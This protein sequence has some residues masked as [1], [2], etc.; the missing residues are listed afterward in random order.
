MH[1]WEQIHS[2][3]I[4]LDWL[5]EAFWVLTLCVLVRSLVY[6]VGGQTATP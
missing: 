2:V 3:Q 5:M 6:T 1:V 4:A